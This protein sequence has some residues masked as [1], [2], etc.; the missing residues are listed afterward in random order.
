MSKL[1][2]DDEMVKTKKGKVNSENWFKTALWQDVW[3][4]ISLSDLLD[5][6]N[7]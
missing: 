3:S 6:Q 4:C 2:N 7:K 5:F 1:V